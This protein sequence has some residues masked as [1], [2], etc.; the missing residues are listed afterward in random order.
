MSDNEYIIYGGPV[1]ET[2]SKDCKSIGEVFLKQAEKHGNKII[3]VEHISLHF[4]YC[5]FKAI[6][7]I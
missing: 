1:I 6:I 4:L 3:M 7:L 2:L 5:F